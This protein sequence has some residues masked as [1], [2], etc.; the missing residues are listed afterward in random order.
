MRPT[1]LLCLALLGCEA[2]ALDADA[3]GDGLD[4][5]IDA[6]DGRPDRGFD[7][8]TF[9]AAGDLTVEPDVALDG[10][11]DLAL[12]GA[13]DLALDSGPALDRGPQDPDL[14]AP[15]PDAGSQDP[16]HGPPDPDPEPEPD[17]GQPD[18]EPDPDLGPPEPDAA[19]EPDATPDAAPE[20][21]PAPISDDFPGPTLAPHWSIYGPDAVDLELRDGALHL[22]PRPF[23]LWFDR[24]RGPLVYQLVDADFRVT[25]R[26]RARLRSDPTQPPAETVHLGGLM[27]RD[28]A[29]PPENY[30]FIVVGRDVDDL[31]VETKNT[32]DGRSAFVGPPWPSSDA[33]L[34]VCR[35]GATFRFYKRPIEGGPW[36]LADTF[37]RPDLPATLQVGAIAYTNSAM[38]DLTVAFDEI[39]FA[40]A[41][42]EADCIAED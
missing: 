41:A 40:P 27:A 37:D 13:A 26:V 39:I 2:D 35:L 9:D 10:A 14:G 19:P 15:D 32:I 18:A 23:A 21:D 22:A 5:A 3:G 7:L 33:A 1:L 20:P 30:A 6:A 11:A 29:T 34:R 8:A 36:Q 31:S 28:P 42:D 4:A 12:D 25:A 17:F 24:N 16:D 38:P